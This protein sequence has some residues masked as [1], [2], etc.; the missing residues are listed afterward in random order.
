MSRSGSASSLTASERFILAVVHA[1]RIG[2]APTPELRQA[3]R[4][5]VDELRRSGRTPEQALV[6]VKAHLADAG[7]RI[8][9]PRLSWSDAS[10]PEDEII[11]S[12]VYWCIEAYFP[13]PR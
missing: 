12:V 2:H 6:A 4:A 5:Y 9:G 8:S 7:L 1:S 13:G 10:R 3:V 11:D